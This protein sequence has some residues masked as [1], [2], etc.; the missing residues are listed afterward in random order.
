MILKEEVLEESVICYFDS[1]NILCVKYNVRDRKMA[2]IFGDGRQYVYEGVIPYHFQR[3]KVSKSTGG[4][5]KE[6]IVKNY[7]GSKVEKKLESEKLQEIKE[8]IESLKP[9]Y[10]K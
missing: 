1:S 10:L 6:H 3:F 5:L 8:F 9:I 7:A 2:V 4:G